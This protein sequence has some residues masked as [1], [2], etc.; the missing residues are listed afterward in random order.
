MSAVVSDEIRTAEALR[1]GAKALRALAA[2]ISGYARR[3]RK[4]YREPDTVLNYKRYKRWRAA[5]KALDA[6]ADKH[7]E[8]PP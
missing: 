2:T 4:G 6:L 1:M 7:P 3:Y 5:A 8:N